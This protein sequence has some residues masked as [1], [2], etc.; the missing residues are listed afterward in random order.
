MENNASTT[1]GTNLLNFHIFHAFGGSNPFY[2]LY[3]G[4]MELLT[5]DSL[6]T[7]NMES[8]DKSYFIN[9]SFK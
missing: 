2:I 4:G 9:S 6:T 8:T 1:Y 7:A 5:E 3:H